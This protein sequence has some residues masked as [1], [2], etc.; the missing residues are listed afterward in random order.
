MV[1]RAVRT[2]LAALALCLAA[3]LTSHSAVTDPAVG[4]LRP[5]GQVTSLTYGHTTT[6]L[7]DGTVLVLGNHPGPLPTGPAA[8]E[9]LRTR[10]TAPRHAGIPDPDPKLW[11]PA[12]H[13]WRRLTDPDCRGHR[14]GHTATELADGRVLIGGGICDQPRALNDE[15]PREPHLRMSLWDPAAKAWAPAGP[16]LRHERL[17]H[18]ATSFSDDSV[19]LV[20]GMADP[21]RHEGAQ[22]PVTDTVERFDGQEMKD[23]PPLRQARAAHGATAL[24]GGSLLVT[25]GFDASGRALES[26]ELWQPAEQRWVPLPPLLAARYEHSATRLAD[27]RVLVAG[28]IGADGQ[29]LRSTEI[30]DGA[31]W[32]EGPQLPWPMHAH[33][34]AALADGSVLIADGQ[35]H[36]SPHPAH[37][38][39]RWMPDGVDWLPAGRVRPGNES[40]WATQAITIAPRADG[41]A[42]VFAAD[43]ILR[44]TPVEVRPVP[45]T[46]A[47]ASRPAIVE[48]PDKRVLL[49]GLV[50]DE[51]GSEWQARVWQRDT[52]AWAGA[53]QTTMAGGVI[54][55]RALWLASGRVLH[56]GLTSTGLACETWAP[57]DPAWR[58]CQP[59][60][61]ET[62]GD[63]PLAL[64]ELPGGAVVAMVSSNEVLSFDPAA[65]AWSRVAVRWRTEGLTYGAPIRA[66]GPLA[67]IE[68]KATGRWLDISD[69]AARYWQGAFGRLGHQVESHGQVLGEVQSR[70]APPAMLWDAKAG[71]WAYIFLPGSAQMGPDAQFLP[72]GCAISSNPLA[73]FD[74]RDG[75]ARRL[76]DP[77]MGASP[78]SLAMRVLSDGHVVFSGVPNLSRDPGGAWLVRKVGCSGFEA[79][80]GEEPYMQPATARPPVAKA[81][82][83]AA[84]APALNAEPHEAILAWVGEH[85][86]LLL[87]VLGPVAGFF[88]LRMVGFRSLSVGGRRWPFRLL[89][90]GLVLI[91]VVPAAVA[92]LN[93]TKA[94]RAE[95]CEESARACLDERTGLIK[96]TPEL[97]AITHSDAP[98]RLPCRMIG[99][100]SSR[101]GGAM[102]RIELRDDGSYDM[103]PSDSGIDGGR[104][105]TGVWAVQAGH[106]VWRHD[107][108][109]GPLDVNPIE[110]DA[111]AAFTLREVNGTR[112]K[113]ERLRA[114]ESKRCVP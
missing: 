82:A 71:Q 87:A 66:A 8:Y 11:D 45:S 14:F 98:T 44:W 70:A 19:M 83:P 86:W 85:R 24:S 108:Y 48:L 103:A 54:A 80:P 112:T 9:V 62:R 68:D 33:A 12:W 113:Y 49:L 39:W 16:A 56:A 81:G 2:R 18:T 91:F 79:V 102:R 111:G 35:W 47:W 110:D 3:G 84:S 58:A 94:R 41:T 32:T 100:W 95:A 57:G 28:G 69:V 51:R 5:A 101:Q 21:A 61:L 13:G 63:A 106:M 65:E 105:Y 20:G 55:T 92:L 53:G 76:D 89:G 46:P 97:T 36:G 1:A 104:H 50:E 22:R 72:D 31:R 17:L 67:E 34:A 38:V 26:V 25:G 107:Q 90:Y 52:D 75:K 109:P 43:T 27:G 88:L 40:D 10:H 78:G 77:G 15:T 59:V 99:V 74:P 6:V 30:L 4:W 37:Q 23:L 93:F 42:L 114:V 29:P 73:I 60:A 96:V 7:N 64:G